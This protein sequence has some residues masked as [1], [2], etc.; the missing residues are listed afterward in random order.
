MEIWDDE[1]CLS[2]LNGN[3]IPIDCDERERLRIDKC[4][5]YYYQSND[6]LMFKGLVVPKLE[7]QRQIIMDIHN[8]I[9]HF[10]EGKFFTKVNSWYFGH[11]MMELVKEFVHTYKN[12]RLVK[13]IGS[14]RL[15]PVE[16]KSIPIWDQFFKIIFDTIGPFLETK[17]GN[18]YVLVAIDHYSKWC[19]VK[20]VMNNDVET[21]AIFF[22]K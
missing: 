1:L 19:E 13:R 10:G 17:H 8:E 3:Q 22:E 12:Y 5:L 11:N 6:S 2:V 16:L 9:G 4:I 18:L 21:D 20:V 7:I 14:V 15:E